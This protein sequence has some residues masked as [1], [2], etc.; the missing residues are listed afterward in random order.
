MA[1]PNG[2]QEA[3][4]LV[5]R[6]CG[7]WARGATPATGSILNTLC[8]DVLEEERGARPEGTLVE[9]G[10][11]GI[12]RI[13]SEAFAAW[14]FGWPTPPGPV[15]RAAWATGLWP[16]KWVDRRLRTLIAEVDTRQAA[17]EALR[18]ELELDWAHL[19]D[20]EVVSLAMGHLGPA[21]QEKALPIIEGALFSRAASMAASWYY[22]K[23]G[24]LARDR[25]HAIS[26]TAT[27][28]ERVYDD[29]FRALAGITGAAIHELARRSA[30][31]GI[32]VRDPWALPVSAW[33][34]LLS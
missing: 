29:P 17:F 34:A 19:A 9:V 16:V 6:W 14:T 2:L 21:R 25:L 33:P 32:H 30:S 12:A 27:A 8:G 7:G 23:I 3:P 10:A 1:A 15:A 28:T 5:K 26:E 13:Q 4:E 20:M 11:D 22:P 18:A 24:G 31:K